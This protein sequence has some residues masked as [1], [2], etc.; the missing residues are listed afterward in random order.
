MQGIFTAEAVD[1]IVAETEIW[2]QKAAV[3]LCIELSEDED[4]EAHHIDKAMQF[5]AQ[6]I[7]L[8]NES[9]KNVE[10][11]R[12]EILNQLLDEP[13]IEITFEFG[14]KDN[15]DFKRAAT[16]VTALFATTSF[17]RGKNFPSELT[18]FL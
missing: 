2:G 4:N 10:E 6:N 13:E 16:D 5:I 12:K 1:E 15:K 17:Y 8:I 11:N 14:I 9:I 18:R 3:A 7:S